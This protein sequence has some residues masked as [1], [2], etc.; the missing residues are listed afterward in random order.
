M[1]ETSSS[2]RRHAK[3]ATDEQVRRYLAGESTRTLAL[4][5]QV[6]PTTMKDMLRRAGVL[7]TPGRARVL[8]RASGNGIWTSGSFSLSRRAPARPLP[9]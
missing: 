8:A 5:E 2:K 7:R 6:A 4:S 3:V 9:K 1:S